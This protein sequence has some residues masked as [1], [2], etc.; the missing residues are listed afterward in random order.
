[1]SNLALTVPFGVAGTGVE[2]IQRSGQP[3]EAIIEPVTAP[4]GAGFISVA[5]IPA[6]AALPTTGLV[7]GQLAF[8]QGSSVAP[9]YWGLYPAGFSPP[10]GALTIPAAA[11]ELGVWAY[12]A[13]G[14]SGEVQV[15]PLQNGTDDWPLLNGV[16][17]SVAGNVPVR[18][19]PGVWQAK[20]IQGIPNG[21][22]LRMSST[23][24][25]VSSLA[26]LISPN[27][28]TAPLSASV[29]IGGA[30]L[31]LTADL[32]AGSNLV[33]VGDVAGVVAGQTRVFLLDSVGPFGAQYLVTVV[34]PSG[35]GSSGTLT[36][37]RPA[38][39]AFPM[40]TS[41]IQTIVS[42]PTDI[43]IEG[44][45]ATVTGT[46]AW[47][48]AFSGGLRCNVSQLVFDSS[49]GVPADGGGGL[50]LLDTGSLDCHF[51]EFYAYDFPTGVGGFAAACER[52]SMA[53]VVQGILG[54]GVECNLSAD[55]DLDI[56]AYGC[57]GY[58]LVILTGNSKVRWS[59]T[60]SGN[61]AGGV[62]I[63]GNEIAGH[64]AE[65][66]FQLTS[67]G[68]E[69][70]NAFTACTSPTLTNC[71]ITNNLNGI[72][73]GTCTGFRGAQ[74]DVSNNSG[75]NV[76]V[77]AGA[78]DPELTSYD[79][80]STFPLL[81]VLGASNANPIVITTGDGAGNPA[82][83]GLGPTGQTATVTIAGVTGNTNANGTNLVA[84][85]ISPTQ[86]SIGVAGNGAYAGGGTVQ[87]LTN[88]GMQ[89]SADCRLAA[90]IVRGNFGGGSAI[91][92]NGIHATFDGLYGTA[93][94]LVTG[95]FGTVTGGGR[96]D[97]HSVVMDF[98]QSAGAFLWSSDV[99]S[100]I[101]CGPDVVAK[102]TTA[103]SAGAG[104]NSSGLVIIE[105]SVDL[106]ACIPGFVVFGGGVFARVAHAPDVP[107]T[108]EWTS[109]SVASAVAVNVSVAQS[110]YP[111]LA[112]VGALGA[113]IAL[114]FAAQDADYEVDPSGFTPGIFTLT[115][116]CGAATVALP[117]TTALFDVRTTG[118]G[119]G[120][121][122]AG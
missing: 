54:E 65:I 85:V 88:A 36:L 12:V 30:S 6:L 72:S 114:V 40:A 77:A 31:G 80:S 103:H 64:D 43:T 55:C 101:Y 13:G 37:D 58:G 17:N 60:F 16:L 74:V 97:L 1:M 8:V 57:T 102:G 59:G 29:L 105:N 34:T 110:A 119:G 78:I 41:T 70:S 67:T 2:L 26:G 66:C 112:L 45:F 19:M 98:E 96:V 120:T 90:G 56:Q 117:S 94:S 69:C 121:I 81:D 73:V 108:K 10:T 23:V 46:G 51:S 86:F 95:T 91:S 5:S 53:M 33:E 44:G 71:R 118:A 42:Q 11:P 52:C 4:P 92:V 22:T 49:G 82:E 106:S 32:V 104:F 61:A 27:V 111:G 47:E 84:T 63:D 3:L 83:H 20:S 39:F 28:Q 68:Y 116:Q 21:T 100:L 107:F 87:Q 18:M 7:K 115:L 48:V 15:Y 109:V 113:S 76:T 50:C 62:V 93:L 35:V 79:A 89:L 25:I 38:F 75:V 122:N 9:S 24:R 14:I 99:T